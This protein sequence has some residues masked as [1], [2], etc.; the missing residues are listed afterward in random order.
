[1]GETDELKRAAVRCLTNVASI[2]G[3]AL[4]KATHIV[5]PP[6]RWSAIESTVPAE[7]TPAH[8]HVCQQ[9]FDGKAETPV[10]EDVGTTSL[11]EFS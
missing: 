9:C 5:W 4:A 11:F 8:R 7:R 3:L 6:K 1:M 2:A 10:E